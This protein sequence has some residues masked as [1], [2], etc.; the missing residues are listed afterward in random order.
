M[1][2]MTHCSTANNNDANAAI[3]TPFDSSSQ[4]P[5]CRFDHGDNR[6][7]CRRR[8]IH[9]E[10]VDNKATVRLAFLTSLAVNVA[11]VVMATTRGG[12]NDAS[13]T[14]AGVADDGVSNSWIRPFQSG[15][16]DCG[17]CQP[18]YLIRQIANDQSAIVPPKYG[19]TL[20]HR[21]SGRSSIRLV[22]PFSKRPGRSPC[23]EC[24]ATRSRGAA[25]TTN[26]RHQSS[27]AEPTAGPQVSAT[28]MAAVPLPAGI[29]TLV[30]VTIVRIAARQRRKHHH[31]QQQQQTVTAAEPTFPT[32]ASP[33]LELVPLHRLNPAGT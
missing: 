8:I 30:V 12:R 29:D 23:R 9:A 6:D 21:Q 28:A 1:M 18:D 19:G 5:R 10:V 24:A 33:Q 25:E 4:E 15:K 13:A 20:C 32:A 14:E 16:S 7:H 26:S 3:T 31:H 17:L 11:G 22:G 27:R 2:M